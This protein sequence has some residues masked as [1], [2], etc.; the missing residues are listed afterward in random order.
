M[1]SRGRGSVHLT[2]LLVGALLFG[3]WPAV[4]EGQSL[5]DLLRSIEEGGGWVRIP[6]EGGSGT[7]TTAALPTG[8]LTLSGCMQVYAATSGRWRIRARDT[9]GEGRLDANVEGGEPVTF[10]YRTGR[11]ARL[12]VEAR[13]S[14]PRDTTLLVWVGLASP[15]RPGRDPCTPIYG[16]G[17]ER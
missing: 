7:L 10:T 12:S 1:S 4:V 9:L 17:D 15:L 11:R 5:V 14:E 3:G 8:G 6:V 2:S 13:W 16:S